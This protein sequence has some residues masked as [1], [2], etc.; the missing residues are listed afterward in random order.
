MSSSRSE[1]LSEYLMNV[2]EDIL[3]KAYSIDSAEKLRMYSAR[4]KRSRFT[5]IAVI[6]A[7][8]AL[9][10]AAVLTV[11][12]LLEQGF[13]PMFGDNNEES[14]PPPWV[15]DEN[16]LVTINSIDSLNYY[17]AMLILSNTKVPKKLIAD[18]FEATPPANNFEFV[19]EDIYYYELD[20]NEVFTVTKVI[21]F[22]IN[23]NDKNSFLASKVGVGVVDVV[24]TE[25]SLDN[26]ITFKNGNRFYS[27]LENGWSPQRRDFSTHKYIEG[28]CIVKNLEQE[29]FSFYVETNRKESVLG[30]ESVSDGGS[31]KYTNSEHEVLGSTYVR[32]ST[33]TFTVS[34]LQK[35]F[36]N[37]DIEKPAATADF[38]C[39]NGIYKFEL[40]GDNTFVYRS[41]D[42]SSALYK[43]G[44]YV[45]E[46]DRVIFTFKVG[47]DAV[48]VAD[49]ELLE[50]ENGF[51]YN[52]DKYI[53]LEP[54][55]GDQS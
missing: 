22:R 30:F 46:E 55:G 41:V 52:G 53:A 38:V 37:E 32:K 33:A 11:P 34:D 36:K 42:G 39:S 8:I 35:Y 7:V 43:T 5:K 2:D 20:P 1:K 18:T 3:E 25:N 10:I 54:T 23:V 31:I 24:I 13:D 26:M 29:N 45:L 27:C 51:W 44:N 49:C 48:E 6:A 47:E 14:L 9:L 17:S 4:Q 28:F 16:E 40:Y 12:A 21:F 15:Y 50:N 19:S